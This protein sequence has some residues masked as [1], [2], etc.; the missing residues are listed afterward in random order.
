MRFSIKKEEE[1][2]KQIV[3]TQHNTSEI[4]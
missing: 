3:I 2:V 4:A 1:F